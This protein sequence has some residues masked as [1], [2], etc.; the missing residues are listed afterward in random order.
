MPSNRH[1]HRFSS[2]CRQEWP[3]LAGSHPV[4]VLLAWV[5]HPLAWAPLVPTVLVEHPLP[6]RR[7]MRL[8][9]AGERIAKQITGATNQQRKEATRHEVTRS[10]EH[11]KGPAKL[12]QRTIHI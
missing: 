2:R 3:V 6:S 4:W 7:L 12:R 1:S 9:W 5:A 10:F 8:T 11:E